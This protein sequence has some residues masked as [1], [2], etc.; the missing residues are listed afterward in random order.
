MKKLKISLSRQDVLD[1][2]A[3]ASV[4]GNLGLFIGTGL[5][6]AIMNKDIRPIA[7][8]WKGLLFKCAKKFGIQKEDLELEGISLPDLASKICRI[9]SV[10]KK[11]PYSESIKKLK[12][13]IADMTAW[14]PDSESRKKY[15]KYFDAIDPS[16]IITTNYDTV[17]ESILTGKGYS[18]S[19]NDQLIAPRGFIPVFHLHGI[20]TNPESIIITQEDYISLF[21]PNQYR[22]QKLPLTIKESLTVL[23]GYNLGDYNVLTAVDWSKNVFNT[24]NSTSHPSGIIQLNFTENP[25]PNPYQFHEGITVLDYSDIEELLEELSTFLLNDK[26]SHD[27]FQKSLK[28]INEN[29][30]NISEEKAMEFIDNHKFRMELIDMLNENGGYVVSGFIEIFSKAMDITWKRAE[31]KNAFYAYH[32]NLIVLLDILENIPLKLMPPALIEAIAY[33]LNHVAPYIG[34]HSGESYKGAEE[35]GKRKTNLDQIVLKELMNIA[36]SR[37]FNHIIEKIEDLLHI[38][39]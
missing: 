14:Y 36:K 12:E 20:R 33:N 32:E 39:K 38:E 26:K 31:P 23:L 25:Q 15:S 13:A 35:W 18:L 4:F 30:S 21:R 11:T 10:E 24:E 17:I 22:L 27:K 37:K 7:L 28:E 9:R 8:S 19:P 5:T 3:E 34:N 29:L 1:Q 16:W 2:I 6:M